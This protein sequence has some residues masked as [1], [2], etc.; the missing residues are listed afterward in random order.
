M[1]IQRVADGQAQEIGNRLKQAMLYMGVSEEYFVIMLRR[2]LAKTTGGLPVNH[3]WYGLLAKL[4]KISDRWLIMG[5]GTMTEPSRY[6][7]KQKIKEP[8]PS[9][10][11]D[12][13]AEKMIKDLGWID[14]HIISDSV[15]VISDISGRE[16][17]RG[18]TKKDAVNDAMKN[19][20]G[21]YP[22]ED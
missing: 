11:N 1:Y 21:V 14:K 15:W 2:E 13:Q 3:S 8:P 6:H 7:V 10:E 5:E 19:T 22:K 4:L 9:V 17:G 12:I 18:E 16:L 20:S